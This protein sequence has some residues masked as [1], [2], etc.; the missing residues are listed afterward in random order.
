MH[1]QVNEKD[2][3]SEGYVKCKETYSTTKHV[4]SII[5]T[6]MPT[7]HHG[8]LDLCNKLSCEVEWIANAGKLLDI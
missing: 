6:T 7:F 3:F 8:E 1:I 2:S 5:P 4:C